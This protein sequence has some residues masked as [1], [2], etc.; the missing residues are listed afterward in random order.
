MTDLERFVQ[1]CRDR[2]LESF[3]IP[4][5]GEAKDLRIVRHEVDLEVAKFHAADDIVFRRLRK[6]TLS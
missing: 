3:G 5:I 4:A 1:H 6:T 2:R